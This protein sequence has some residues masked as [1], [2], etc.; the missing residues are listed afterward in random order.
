LKLEKV[1]SLETAVKG[2]GKFDIRK[3]GEVIAS[4]LGEPTAEVKGR[5]EA[6]YKMI[7]FP[8]NQSV[9]PPK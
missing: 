9:T 5:I 6:Q 2:G 1:K 8:Q 3:Y 4:G 7:N